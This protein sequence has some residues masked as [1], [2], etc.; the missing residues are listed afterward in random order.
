MRPVLNFKLKEI[1]HEDLQ[2]VIETGPPKFRR[3]PNGN[4]EREGEYAENYS[5]CIGVGTFSLC[6]AGSNWLAS[7]PARAA[8]Q[9]TPTSLRIQYP[10][11]FFREDWKLASDVP[12]INNAQEPEHTV[13]QGDVG[14]PN[15]EVHLY[16]DKVGPRIPTLPFLSFTSKSISV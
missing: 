16:G 10:P 4:I 5:S 11:L 8:G 9:Q 3:L 7:E 6:L 1:T 2:P 12:N 14:N 13:G 15:L